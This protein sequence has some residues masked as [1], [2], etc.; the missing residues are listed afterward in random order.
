MKLVPMTEDHSSSSEYRT[1][2]SH[3]EE[4]LKEMYSVK[5]L[6][7]RHSLY[8]MSHSAR[9]DFTHEILKNEESFFKKLKLE[10][11]RRISIICRN[12]P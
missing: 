8:I 5:V 11:D 9:Y 10:K 6:L 3:S 1:Q 4:K 12:E 2:P 7:K